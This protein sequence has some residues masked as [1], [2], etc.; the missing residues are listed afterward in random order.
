MLM[1]LVLYANPP[2]LLN[3]K[4][5]EPFLDKIEVFLKKD[6]ENSSLNDASNLVEEEKNKVVKVSKSSSLS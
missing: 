5:Q 1:L 3:K 4:S 2:K 6:L